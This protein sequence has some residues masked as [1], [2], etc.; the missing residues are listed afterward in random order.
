MMR[1]RYRYR[2]PDIRDRK[3][4]R[5]NIMIYLGVG[6]ATASTIPRLLT[7]GSGR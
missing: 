6:L 2:L 7:T 1:P 5:A 3:V 4:A